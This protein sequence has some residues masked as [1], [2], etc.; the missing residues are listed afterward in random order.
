MTFPCA[1]TFDAA[2][3]RQR[4]RDLRRRIL[5]V[6]QGT[7]LH[8]APAFSCLE[9]VDAA[10][11]GLI[12]RD[13]DGKLHDTF[14]LSKGHGAAAQYAVLEKVGLLPSEQMDKMCQVGGRLGAHP[15]FGMPGIEASTGSL[16][17]GLPM[18]PGHGP[19]RQVAGRSTA[20][21][22]SS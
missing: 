16:G 7:P 15:D 2:A 10:Y 20:S 3:A 4:C 6:S 19:G 12:R 17:H 21:S 11:F 8:V 13:A 9:M 18:S 1:P 22:M 14:I 5:A